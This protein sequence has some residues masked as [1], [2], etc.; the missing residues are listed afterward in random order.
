MRAYIIIDFK[1]IKRITRKYYNNYIVIHLTSQ[2]NWKNSL[3]D[4]NHQYL[5]KKKQS[6]YPY[7]LR[8]LK[9]K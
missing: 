6:K 3:K 1:D 8:K 7:I 9:L 5:I 2:I 4:P